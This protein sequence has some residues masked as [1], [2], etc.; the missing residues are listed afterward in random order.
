MVE[1][2]CSV[3]RLNLVVGK[4]R[5]LLD[6]LFP[7]GV[8]SHSG[9]LPG[10]LVCPLFTRVSDPK[11]CFWFWDLVFLNLRRPPCSHPTLCFQKQVSKD[12]RTG[13]LSMVPFLMALLVFW[14]PQSPQNQ[15]ALKLKSHKLYTL[16]VLLRNTLI[17]TL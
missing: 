3:L 2:D 11:T 12:T 13:T 10:N 6:L 14:S 15:V 17:T 9:W 1:L 8:L 5:V 7:V 4:M 16:L